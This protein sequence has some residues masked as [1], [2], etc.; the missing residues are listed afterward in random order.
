MTKSLKI[1]CIICL[2]VLCIPQFYLQATEVSVVPYLGYSQHSYSE[3]FATE[4]S[5]ATVLGAM[6]GL[7][8]SNYLFVG[9][10]YHTGGIYEHSEQIEKSFRNVMFGGGIA[11]RFSNGRVWGGYYDHCQLEDSNQFYVMKGTAVKVSLSI[12]VKKRIFISFDHISQN[13]KEN[14]YL[15][16]DVALPDKHSSSISGISIS[17]PIDFN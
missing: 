6:G 5:T 12:R 9:L 8:I 13:I 14:S 16:T 2:W 4:H 1:Y 17:A 11:W 10:D 15:G 7:N 3:G